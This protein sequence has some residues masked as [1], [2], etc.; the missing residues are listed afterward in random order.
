[1]A[2]A[3]RILE[4]VES[5]FNQIWVM[6]RDGWIDLEV[7]GATHSSFHPH[8]WLTGYSWDALCA[9]AML[10]PAPPKTAL[11]L[12]LG[13]G[14]SVRQLCHVCPGIEVVA[15]EIDPAVVDVAYRYMGL[16]ELPV[17]VIVD[18]AARW[19][20]G[21]RDTFDAVLDD[22]YLCGNDDVFR[23]G[24][25]AGG[26]LDALMRVTSDDGVT[27]CNL[28]TDDGHREIWQQ[29]DVAFEE[30]FAEV[31][32]LAPPR[33]LNQILVGGRAVQ[34]QKALRRLRDKFEGRD[35]ALWD[36]IAVTRKK[37]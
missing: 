31:V 6:E 9:G 2:F 34:G 8:R 4:T 28:I 14:T 21:C 27:L 29:T 37:P 33:G 12:G 5:A 10:A 32:A 1:M 25:V 22:L 3:G 20:T 13:G 17:E 30:R 19:L 16:G 11:V 7:Q 18:D 15:L 24:P 35:Q 23:D 36:T 26:R